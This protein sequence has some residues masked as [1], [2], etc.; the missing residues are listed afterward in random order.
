MLQ[1]EGILVSSSQFSLSAIQQWLK[2]NRSAGFTVPDC[3]EPLHDP[4][5]PVSQSSIEVWCMIQGLHAPVMIS[6]AIPGFRSVV[7]WNWGAPICST[8]CSFWE[9]EGSS[10]SCL[11]T[12]HPLGENDCIA[13]GTNRNDGFIAMALPGQVILH[14][15]IS[16][17]FS[18]NLCRRPLL[19]QWRLNLYLNLEVQFLI[20]SFFFLY[21][22]FLF[23][24][25]F[26]TLAE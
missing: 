23:I 26:V 14:V 21:F 10:K 19:L 24:W 13:F 8:P 9:I 4:Q 22:S 16:M 15:P 12:F 17:G 20:A 6:A 11:V 1:K 5:A 18:F 2:G 3:P 25:W 7:Q